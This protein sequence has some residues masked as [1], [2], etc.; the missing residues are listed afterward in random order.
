MSTSSNVIIIIFRFFYQQQIALFCTLGF[1]L[2]RFNQIGF[3]LQII[4]S[5]FNLIKKGE[6]II[7]QSSAYSTLKLII[8]HLVNSTLYFVFDVLIFELVSASEFVIV[9]W[10]FLSAKRKCQKMI[11]NKYDFSKRFLT[12][13]TLCFFNK[14]EFLKSQLKSTAFP[15]GVMSAKM[16]SRQQISSRISKSTEKVRKNK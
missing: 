16:L 10:L 13:G 11:L 12:L 2:A 6:K 15:T 7:P 9:F 4:F 3:I 8:H 5:S 14:L 1:W